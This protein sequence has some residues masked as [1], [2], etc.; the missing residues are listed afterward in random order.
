MPAAKSL[1]PVGSGDRMPPKRNLNARKKRQMRGE[2]P[3]L[4]KVVPGGL[5]TKKY[6][7]YYVPLC[8]SGCT[9]VKNIM[10]FLDT[11]EWYAKPL[12]IHKDNDALLRNAGEDRDAFNEA[13]R[14]RKIAFSFVREPFARAYSAFNEKIFQQSEHS[15]PRLRKLLEKEYGAV[16][17]AEGQEY[18][19]ADHGRNFL[20][21]LRLVQ[22]TIDGNSNERLNPHWIPQKMALDK[23]RQFVNIDFVGRIENFVQ[24]M[25]FVLDVAKIDTP[26]DLTVRFNEGARP[27]YKL[28]E[29]MTEEIE[30]A[31]TKAYGTDRKYFGYA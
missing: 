23:Y 3:V 27:P 8:K 20:R 6:P 1:S 9:T 30:Y 11:G 16:F 13:V 5:C 12:D 17:P 21:F 10:Y 22:D 29:I 25:Q 24:G 7:L 31:L 2:Q 28:D 19:A 26:L 15:F 14:N 4:E 18:S